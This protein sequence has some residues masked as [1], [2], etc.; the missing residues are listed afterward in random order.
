MEKLLP[1]GK[2]VTIHLPDHGLPSTGTVTSYDSIS[3][4]YLI[5][6]NNGDS[7]RNFTSSQLNSLVES[8]SVGDPVDLKPRC[9]R[10]V[11]R[12]HQGSGNVDGDGCCNDSRVRFVE[13]SAF[14]VSVDYGCI[15]ERKLGFDLNL[16]A[17][18]MADERMIES[19]TQFDLNIECD[20]IVDVCVHI[21]QNHLGTGDSSAVALQEEAGSKKPKIEPSKVDAFD[22]VFVEEAGE[23]DSCL[24]EI[25]EKSSLTVSNDSDFSA[26][27]Y[28]LEE[29]LVNNQDSNDLSAYQSVTRGRKRRRQTPDMVRPTPEPALRRS[30]RKSGTTFSSSRAPTVTIFDSTYGT[31]IFDVVDFSSSNISH[32]ITMQR[33]PCEEIEDSQLPPSKLQLPESSKDLNLD[34]VSVLNFI[35]IYSLLRSFSTVLFLSPFEMEDFCEALKSK[36]PTSLFDQTHVA[37]LQILRKHLHSLSAEGSQSASDCLR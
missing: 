21:S 14:E 12:K 26:P 15:E 18:E 2:T 24:R 1:L 16:A 20:Q 13:D 32:N 37:I 23:T 5:T 31:P 30:A 22:S 19:R 34:G 9:G 27:G 35:S 11:K 17:K 33:S 36:S 3:D 25:I 10:L 29:T 28:Q 4:S 8:E 7:S 6:Y